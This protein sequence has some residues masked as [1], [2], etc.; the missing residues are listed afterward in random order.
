MKTKVTFLFT[1]VLLL[2]SIGVWA[3]DT[4]T[5]VLLY[6]DFYDNSNYWP[7]SNDGTN[8]SYI[9]DGHLY[10][11]HTPTEGGNNAK[12]N[13]PG[14]DLNSDF[15]IEAKIKHTAGIENNAFGLSFGDENLEFFLAQNGY[16]MVREFRNG[17]N[18]DLVAWVS[19]TLVN[20]N[21]TYNTLKVTRESGQWKFFLNGNFMTS[22][23]AKTLGGSE[24]GFQLYQN[25]TIAV[26]YISVK[27]VV[28]NS[29]VNNYN[30]NYNNNQNNYTDTKPIITVYEP[31]SS[32]GYNVV[33]A[34]TVRLA[35]K[36]MDPDGIFELK[37][38]G[39]DVKF[40]AD[41]YFSTEVPLAP[42]QNTITIVATDTRRQATTK[43]IEVK[44]EDDYNV[45]NNVNNQL[46]NYNNNNNNQNQNQELKKQ[47]RLAL[48]IGNSDYAN[49]GTLANPI[50]DV[51][52]MK[53]AL[54][55]L[56]F[57]VLKYENCTQKDMRKA[58]DE[59]GQQ[60]PGY[61]VGMFFY[62]GHGVQV[63]GNNYL[64]PTDAALK[65]KNDV[66]Y[67][68]VDAGRVLSKMEASQAKTNIVVLDA[69]RDNPFERSWSRSTASKGLA[70][71]NAPSGSFVAYAT[72]PGMTASDGI[73]GN[74]LY[75]SALLEQLSIPD[76]TIEQVFK[77]V[78]T[79]VKQKS[80]GKQVPW[81][82]TSLEGTFKFR[83]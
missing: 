80:G 42:G 75:T 62:A 34:K 57:T 44:R 76:L 27:Q 51:R 61:D 40:M 74:G 8:I 17:A 78:R 29:Y 55:E 66:E 54:E 59:F 2:S 53:T 70:F 7:T 60:L 21:G 50:N 13:I 31:Q 81:E 10:I 19:T 18:A 15:I 41:G 14:L 64:V 16:Y 73:N 77:N 35:G 30:N 71:M 37:V 11:Q 56:G 79:T 48:L 22:L 63:D 83:Y 67:D 58:M 25:Q 9:S 69:C 23:T 4:R 1:L 68:C 43:V 20:L 82:S 12:I 52:S 36:A 33:K 72:S 24:V 28:T 46:V 6:D 49:G 5:K 45:N 38:N 39:A 26:D 3:Q 47:K 65:T 32:R